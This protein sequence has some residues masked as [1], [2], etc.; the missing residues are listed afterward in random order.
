MKKGL[1]CKILAFGIIVM[2]IGVGTHPAFAVDTKQP[3]V[4]ITNE[5]DCGCNAKSDSGICKILELI[6][7]SL[8]ERM[9]LLIVLSKV[10]EDIPT[11]IHFFDIL[12]LSIFA[13]FAFIVDLAN[14]LNCDWVGP[15]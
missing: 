12:G 9:N 7:L 8:D 4:N 1:Y 13:R 2:F 3:I 14:E 5:E 10:F 6:A 11:I 15:G